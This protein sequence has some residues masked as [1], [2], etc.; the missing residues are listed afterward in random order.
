MN[1]QRVDDVSTTLKGG[2]LFDQGSKTV[3]RAPASTV[4]PPPRPTSLGRLCQLSFP[5]VAALERLSIPRVTKNTGVFTPVPP[6]APTPELHTLPVVNPNDMSKEMLGNIRVDPPRVGS[7]SESGGFS[8]RWFWCIR[9]SL[10]DWLIAAF[11]AVYSHHTFSLN[12]RFDH[13][14]R[15]YVLFI[16][17]ERV[18][19]N[20]L[21][22]VIA[23]V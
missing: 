23:V 10:S 16:G 13:Q 3:E 5:Y 20:E 2:H 9:S 19:T 22:R 6:P 14:G 8:T 11:R 4:L 18:K 7:A 15:K 12:L 21:R 1:Q 17:C